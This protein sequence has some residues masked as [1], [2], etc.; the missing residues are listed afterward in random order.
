MCQALWEM[1]RVKRVV[2]LAQMEYLSPSIDKQQH[3]H[4]IGN[5]IGF[6]GGTSGKE[7]ACQCRRHKRHRFNSWVRKIPCRRH[8]KPVQYSCLEKS[9]DRGAWWAT[10]HGVAKSWT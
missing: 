2:V 4:P 10:V 3:N 9:M 8:G 6:P 7:H 5:A 1:V